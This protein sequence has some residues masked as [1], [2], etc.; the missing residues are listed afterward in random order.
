MPDRDK[1]SRYAKA[2]AKEGKGGELAGILLEAADANRAFEGCLQYEV[3]QSVFDSDTVW[4]TEAW[5]DQ[6]S[7]KASL[8]DDSNKDLIERARPLIEDMEVIELVPLGGI[9]ARLADP[10]AAT[11]KHGYKLVNVDEV[12]DSAK[13]HGLAEI[14]E[15]RFATGDLEASQVGVSLFRMKPGQRQPFGHHHDRAEEVYFVVSGSGRVK[16]DDEILDL[17]EGDLLRVAPELI[18]CF[19]AGPEG[20]VYYAAGQHMEGDGGIEPGWWTD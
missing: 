20:M 4:V 16:L 18:R 19:E 2:T 15:A 5:A 7:I 12:K 10:R 3:H 17:T 6:A 14:Q 1:I 8:E 13:D 9:E 11:P